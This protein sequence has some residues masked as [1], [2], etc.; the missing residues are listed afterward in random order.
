MIFFRVSPKAIKANA[1]KINSPIP[2]ACVSLSMIQLR[3]HAT[4][5]SASMA[6][7]R[8]PSQAC[9]GGVLWFL[10]I[11]LVIPQ[12]MKTIM[13]PRQNVMRL[14]VSILFPEVCVSPPVIDVA[15][16]EESIHF[17]HECVD[18]CK[19]CCCQSG[20]EP[21]MPHRKFVERTGG[22]AVGTI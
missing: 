17:G 9:Q 2:A 4:V 21:V 7:S 15:E 14:I 16:S 5:K 20:R 6:V 19:G 18:G 10:F 22:Y 1:P 8:T 11:Q 3:N 13:A 12:I